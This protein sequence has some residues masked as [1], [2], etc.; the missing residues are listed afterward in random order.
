MIAIK[1]A[2]LIRMSSLERSNPVKY[3]SVIDGWSHNRICLKYISIVLILI[4]NEF[5]NTTIQRG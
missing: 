1:L 3:I 5:I 2:K 4:R